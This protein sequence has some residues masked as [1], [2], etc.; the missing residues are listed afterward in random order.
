MYKC[1][2]CNWAVAENAKTCPNCG[3]I[4]KRKAPKIFKKV[5]FWVI[6]GVVIFVLITLI[7]QARIDAE[8]K[9]WADEVWQEIYSSEEYIAN[10]ERLKR[11]EELQKELDKLGENPN[12]SQEDLKRIEE[13]VEEAHGLAMSTN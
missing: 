13:I 9:A 1:P 8:A 12:P 2:T 11:I 5:W 6:V 3:M 10:Q 4:F 7:E